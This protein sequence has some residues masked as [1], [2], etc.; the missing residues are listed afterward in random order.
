MSPSRGASTD[1]GA[2]VDGDTV[3]AGGALLGVVPPRAW[4]LL[5]LE[6]VT[7]SPWDMPPAGSATGSAWDPVPLGNTGMP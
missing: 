7:G 6:A 4:D 3:L 5:P 1:A 2:G